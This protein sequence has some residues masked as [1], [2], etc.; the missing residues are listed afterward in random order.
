MEDVAHVVGLRLSARPV[1][2]PGFDWPCVSCK[3]DVHL[4][5]STLILVSEG[6]VV[7]CSICAAP[8]IAADPDAEIMRGTAGWQ[9]TL[10]VLRAAQKPK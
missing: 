8:L 1:G 7:M 6:A 2:L 10:S 4:A 5:S 9:E 3:Q